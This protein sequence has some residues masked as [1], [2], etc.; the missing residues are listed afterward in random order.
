MSFMEELKDLGVDTDEALD[1]VMGDIST[2][3]MLLDIF[4][5]SVKDNP[6]SLEEFG[7]ADLEPLIQKI[8]MFKGVTGNLSIKPLYTGYQK[9]LS[10][11]RSG[12]AEEARAGY[13]SLQA[14]QETIVACL[15]RHQDA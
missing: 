15:R 11:L 6:I 2:Y 5:G 4:T 7:D 9:I 12:Q 13:E 1:R 8:H 14:V 10:Q 3:E